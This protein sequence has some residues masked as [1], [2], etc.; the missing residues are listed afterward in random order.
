MREIARRAPPGRSFQVFILGG[1]TAVYAGWRMSTIDAD[2]YAAQI[3]VFRDIQDIKERLELNVEFARPE[4][5]VPALADTGARHVL[6]ESIGSVSFYH[7]DPYAQLLSKVVRGFRKD[8]LDAEEL[9]ASGMV[10]VEQFRAL[11]HE[12]PAEAYA[13][14]PALSQAAVL[15]AVDAFLEGLRQRR[16]TD[17]HADQREE[18]ECPS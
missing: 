14:Y 12:I 1:S 13:R 16:G 11:V 5:F 9:I 4:D 17:L 7:Y 18:P 8:V 10:D 15:N 3:D 2:L 6:I